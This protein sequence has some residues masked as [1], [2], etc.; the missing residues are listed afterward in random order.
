MTSRLLLGTDGGV[1]QS[2][3]AGQAW[4]HLNSIPAGQFYRITLDDS[5][6]YRIAGGLQ[7]NLNWVG[8]SRT[9]SKEGIL[10]SDWVNIGGGDGF[11]CAFD[12][13]DRDLIYAESQG[14]LH[15][16]NLRTGELK[17]LR[18]NPAEGQPAFRFNWNAPLFGSRHD[19]GALYLAGNR[20]FRLT[21]RGENWKVISPDLSTKDPQKTTATGS[22]AETYGVVY[23]LAESPVKAGLLWAGTDDGK[24]WLT[25]DSPAAAGSQPSCRRPRAVGGRVKAEADRAEVATCGCRRCPPGGCVWPT[26]ASDGEALA[27]LVGD[28]DMP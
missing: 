8:P 7:D 2:Y 23:T 4:L 28:P 24:L 22:G 15:R 19:K 25:E 14:M 9:R 26:R 17:A 10:N 3:E 11:S 1:Y 5:V 21:E 18:P 13:Q 27:W 20:V 12:P 16:F 6:P